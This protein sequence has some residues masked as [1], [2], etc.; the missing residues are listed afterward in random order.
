MTKEDAVK[1]RKWHVVDATGVPLGRLATQVA[2]L[3][4][5]K[6]KPTFTPHVDCG[7]Y[8]VVINASKVAL[9]GNRLSQ[10]K[11]FT[12]SGYIG[13]IKEVSAAEL[14]EKHPER[15]IRLAVKRMVKRGALGH[16][17]IKKLKVYGGEEHPHSAQQPQTVTLH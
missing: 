8:V 15:M 6:H 10:K 12:H 17:I 2:H 16:Q 13:G 9:K 5:G 4:R 7:D 1:G 3:L 14:R 11:Y